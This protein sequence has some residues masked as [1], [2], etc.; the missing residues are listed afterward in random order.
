MRRVVITGLGMISPIGK[1]VKEN[2]E[3]IKAGKCGIGLIESFDTSNLKVK[4]AAEIKD[5]DMEQYFDKKDVKRADRFNQ[6]GRIAA[7]EAVVDSKLNLDE[8]DKDRFGVV[9]ASGIG[10][11]QTFAENEDVLREKGASRISPFFIPKTL[12]NLAAGQIAIEHGARGYCT[13]IVTACA[14][15]TNAVGD[16]YHRIKFGY[17]DIILAG[18]SEAPITELGIAGFQSMNALHSGDNPNRASIPFDKDRSGF[19]M[20]EGGGAL[21]LEELEHALKRGAHIYAEVVGYGCSCDAH[22]ITAPLETG[23]GASKA[24]LNAIKEANIKPNEIG[25]INAHGTSTPL[26]DKTETNAIKLAFGS[27]TKVLVSSTKGNTG[28]LLGAA[29]AIEAIYIAKALE[30]SYAPAT[31]NYQN[32]DEVCDLDVV[33]NVGRNVDLNYAMSN[34]LGFG[35]HNASIIFKKWSE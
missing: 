14:S 24:M 11:M 21:V 2:W 9:F 35:G 18:G 7:K 15:G 3:S 13:S 32:A 33:P 5:L 34:S 27:D 16:A 26:N 22:H 30:D 23:E 20:G 4:V 10:G 17:E 1:D 12:I 25:Y 29:G 8:I 31:I 19:V 6:L 28:H